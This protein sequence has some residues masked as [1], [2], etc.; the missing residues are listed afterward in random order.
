MKLYLTVSA[1]IL[2]A[3]AGCVNTAYSDPVWHGDVTFTPEERLLVENGNAYLAASIGKEPY[4]IVWDL[5]HTVDCVTENSLL[6]W[7]AV[8]DGFTWYARGRC[9]AIMTE[10]TGH[11]SATSAHEFGHM[12]GLGHLE[13]GEAGLMKPVHNFTDGHSD[14]WSQS[15]RAM[16]VRQGVCPLG[17]R[18]GS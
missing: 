8:R 5:P 1:A 3:C 6:K 9:I 10:V 13:P 16:C 14:S 2:T 15:D 7:D 18:S 17:T 11:L 12:R 4:D